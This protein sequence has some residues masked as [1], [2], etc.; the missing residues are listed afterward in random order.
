RDEQYWEQLETAPGV[1]DFTVHNHKFEYYMQ[2]LEQHDL[3]PHI[4]FGY[5]SVHHDNNST[6]YT[7]AGRQAFASFVQAV[8]THYGNQLD[9]VGVYNEFNAR[10]FG[11]RGNGPADSLPAYYYPLLA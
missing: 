2:Q 4:L 1:Y 8:L 3:K 11:D 6:P 9:T 5:T 10:N 7:N